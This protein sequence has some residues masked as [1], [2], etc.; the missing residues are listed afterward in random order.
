M[1]GFINGTRWAQ[2]L[3]A[4]LGNLPQVQAATFFSML[5]MGKGHR[6]T[7]Y[8]TK[9]MQLCKEFDPGISGRLNVDLVSKRT[10]ETFTRH[11]IL[12]GG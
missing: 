5:K 8:L 9:A 6:V 7:D 1:H 4:A 3:G 11:S 12:C 10:P 2:Y